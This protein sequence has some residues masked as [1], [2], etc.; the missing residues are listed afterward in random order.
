MEYH[1]I[2]A[3][4]SLSNGII[5][6]MRNVEEQVQKERAQIAS[7]SKAMESARLANA[8]KSVFLSRMSHDIRTPL[9]G[10]IGILEIDEQHR[11]DP[12]LLNRNREK[13]RIAAHHLLSLVNDILDMS[14]L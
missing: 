9:N 8:A 13:L 7:M 5:V 10:I 11:D 2:K 4:S 1:V 14:K 6:G 12:E 3:D